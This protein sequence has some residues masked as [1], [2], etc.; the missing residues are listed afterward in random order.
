MQKY[1]FISNHDGRRRNFNRIRDARRAAL[2]E[3]GAKIAIHNYIGHVVCW[4]E[5]AGTTTDKTPC[6]PVMNL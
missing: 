1:F 6:L 2:H 4:A 5:T 3:T